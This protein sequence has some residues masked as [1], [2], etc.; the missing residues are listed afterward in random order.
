MRDY[1]LNSDIHLINKLNLKLI[2]N[3]FSLV[4]KKYD[5]KTDRDFEKIEIMY[6][7]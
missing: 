6:P 2:L 5:L 1:I 3:I 7:E 4:Y